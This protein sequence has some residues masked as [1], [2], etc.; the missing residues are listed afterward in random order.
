MK[1]QI[2]SRQSMPVSII[3]FLLLVTITLIGCGILFNINRVMRLD[4]VTL[5]QD[6][7]RMMR[8]TSSDRIPGNS[9]LSIIV[10]FEQRWNESQLVIRYWLFDSAYTA[11]RGVDALSGT[12]AAELYFYPELSPDAVIGDATWCHLN[13]HTVKMSSPLLFVKDNVGVLVMTS[14][15]SSNQLHFAQNI[16]R[17]IEAKIAAVVE[18]K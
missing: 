9:K 15:P 2:L 8:L 14:R 6:D 18:K 16:A 12:I 7:L 13:Q 1:I 10:G 17:K 11:K 5:T 4:P 3:G